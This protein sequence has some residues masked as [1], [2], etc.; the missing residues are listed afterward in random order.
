MNRNLILGI[1]IISTAMVFNAC[2]G[3]EPAISSITIGK[4]V[5]TTTNLDVSVFRNGDTIREAETAAEFEILG[6]NEV[7]TWIYYNDDPANGPIY[8][9][10]YN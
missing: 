2:G 7:P 1:L 5:W 10:L 3:G 4:Q 6:Q 9:K 8:G